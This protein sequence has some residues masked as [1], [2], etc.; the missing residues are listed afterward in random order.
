[1]V[2]LLRYKFSKDSIYIA[3]SQD[4]RFFVLRDGVAVSEH[5]SI[6]H[7]LRS[8]SFLGQPAKLSEW[9]FC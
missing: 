1:M 7:A 9:D 4:L 8:L 5:G 2:K 6:G 3:V